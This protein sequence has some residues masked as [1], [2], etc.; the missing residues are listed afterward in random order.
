MCRSHLKSRELC[1]TSLRMAYVQK[2]FGTI[3]HQ[4]FIYSH[5]FIYPMMCLCQYRFENCYSLGYNPILY[6]FSFLIVSVLAVGSTFFWFLYPFDILY[7][8]WVLKFGGG[9]YF[10]HYMMLCSPFVQ[11]LTHFLESANSPKNPDLFCWIMY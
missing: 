11:F 4:R 1:F 3:L 9:L 6:L 2:L 7:Y 10:C 8:R 5:S